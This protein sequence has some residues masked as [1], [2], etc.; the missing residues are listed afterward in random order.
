M[1]Y[2]MPGTLVFVPD[3]SLTGRQIVEKRRLG[4]TDLEVNV[5]GLGG[6]PVGRERTSDEEAMET[7]WASL[8]G[9]VN[10][11]DTAPHYGLG[12]SERRIGEALQ[13]RPDLAKGCILSTKT[14]SYGKEKDYSYDRTLRSVENSLD[15]L[16]VDY[17]PIVHIHAVSSAEELEDIVRGE[18]AYAA[19]SRLREEGVVGNIGVGTR[20]LTTLDFAVESDEFDVLMMANRY[21][22]I[23]QAGKEIIVRAIE[24]DVGMII[25]GA[26]ATGI[27]AKGSAH[28]RTTY[29][30]S[31]APADVRS[32]VAKIEGLCEEAGCSLPA[33]AVQFCLRNP[34]EGAV[35]VLGAR[36]R[37]Q[38]EQ[39]VRM[40]EEDIPESFW[41]Q[42]ETVIGGKRPDL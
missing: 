40:M 23:D 6:A 5:V 4:R 37:D 14:G 36:T 28:P 41:Q 15:S 39:N 17:L 11:I 9:G 22:L 29:L 32:H 13:R 27:L 25:A 16:G 18:A 34:V 38:A 10:L 26:Y 35:T 19:L 42:L 3:P 20:S 7:V 12:R 33:A 24:R 2:Q 31:R 1:I 21:N 8:E 30:Y